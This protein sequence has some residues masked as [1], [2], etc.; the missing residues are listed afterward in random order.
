[1]QNP[2]KIF[3][4]KHRIKQDFGS[5]FQHVLF[6][7]SVMCNS[8]TPWTTARQ[9]SLFFTIS[10]SLLNSCLLSRWCHPTI[11]ASVTPFSSC[12]Q[13]F[14]ASGSF[15]VSPLFA[16][17]GQSFGASASASVLPMNIQGWFPLGLT[18]LQSKGPSRVLSNTTV[19]KHQF[20]I[21]HYYGP[22]LTSINDYWKKQLQLY[23]SLSNMWGT[24]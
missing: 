21:S 3:V 22:T 1:M 5:N 16:S 24:L 13:S 10:W 14:P 17:G 19:Q 6:T 4:G 7:H 20:F 8:A 15:P 18:D 9:D 23:G 2:S 12:L 11:S